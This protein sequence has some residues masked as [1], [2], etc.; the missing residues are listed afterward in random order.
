[1]SPRSPR[2][3]RRSRDKQKKRKKKKKKNKKPRRKHG[4]RKRRRRSLPSPHP[5]GVGQDVHVRVASRGA[6]PLQKPHPS[7]RHP[8]ERAALPREA[9]RPLVCLPPAA[10]V[11]KF[12]TR[13][14]AS[15]ARRASRTR[16]GSCRPW[17]RPTSSP[18]PA[19]TDAPLFSRAA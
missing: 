17:A 1:S 11:T 14:I 10:S 2:N 15:S 6:L 18:S 7:R 5:L 9:R 13:W 3:L 19:R 4:K 12:T 8:R 16:C